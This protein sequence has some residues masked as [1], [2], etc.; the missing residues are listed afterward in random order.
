MGMGRMLRLS[1]MVRLFRAVPELVVLMKG[2]LV[3]SRSV[4][5]F[6][7]LWIIIIYVFAV[8]FRQITDGDAIGDQ[9]FETVPDAMNTLLL[10]GILPDTSQLVNDM[11]G[12]NP[13]LWPIVMFFILLSCVTIMYMLVGVL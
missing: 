3:A 6:F 1:R 11:A 4:L 8:I 2:I 10:D 5:V 7:L 13:I 9:Y 12:A